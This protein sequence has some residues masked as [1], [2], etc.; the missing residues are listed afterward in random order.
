MSTGSS[1]TCTQ[2]TGWKLHTWHGML[3]YGQEDKME[4]HYQV[5]NT[6]DISDEDLSIGCDLYCQYGNG[7]VHTIS[8]RCSSFYNL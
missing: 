7:D 5:M 1:V 4:P 6:G 3:G 2:L 8:E